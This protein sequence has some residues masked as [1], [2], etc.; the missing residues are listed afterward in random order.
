MEPAP[1]PTTPRSR[2]EW[3][4]RHPL[5]VRLTHW[6]NVV[7]VVFLLGSGM[8]IFNAHPA[9]Y[10]GDTSDARPPV[11][12]MRAARDGNR[13]T[14]LTTVAGITFETTGVLGFSTSSDGM[15]AARGFP[16]WLTIPSYQDL[17]TGRLWHFLFAW[18]FVV[19]GALYLLLALATGRA[20]RELW[21]SGEQVR[22]LGRTI[23]DHLRLR[24]PH[25]PEARHYNVL[26]KLSYL[27]RK[28]TRL[29]SSHSQQS[30][31]P[32]SA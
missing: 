7:C 16:S 31:M 11:L 23:G 32:S 21:P 17:A 15:P 10:F 29:N 28:S 3:I 2:R 13:V 30:R 12:A 20:A 1:A 4:Y 26:Q 9:L 24:F 18:I 5:F 27:D 22:A 8:Q 19:N 25:G 14:G 6:I